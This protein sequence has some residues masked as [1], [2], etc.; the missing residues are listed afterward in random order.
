MTLSDT[1]YVEILEHAAHLMENAHLYGSCLELKDLETGES[2]WSNS[3]DA[4]GFEKL[5]ESPQNE[6]HCCCVGALFL[7]AFQTGHSFEEF[8]ATD[9]RL[10]NENGLRSRNG[11]GF[12]GLHGKSDQLGSKAGE[13]LKKKAEQAAAKMG[14]EA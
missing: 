3:L 4:Y 11:S 8:A 9:D 14:V 13:W 1:A 7:A 5:G 10:C 2:Y 12:S 6:I